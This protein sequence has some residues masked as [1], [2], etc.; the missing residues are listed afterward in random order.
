MLDKFIGHFKLR[1]CDG[2]L[3]MDA[4]MFQTVVEDYLVEKKNESNFSEFRNLITSANDAVKDDKVQEDEFIVMWDMVK[5][6]FTA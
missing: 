5:K 3:I 6:D 4:K 2:L 1:D